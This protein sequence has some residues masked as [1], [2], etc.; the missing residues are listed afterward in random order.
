M[1]GFSRSFSGSQKTRVILKEANSQNAR[2][3]QQMWFV[4]FMQFNYQD[5]CRAHDK[6]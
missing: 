2:K 3:A 4:C 1:N 6:N 5:Y